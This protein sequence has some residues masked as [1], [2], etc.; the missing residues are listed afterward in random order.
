MYTRNFTI[1]WEEKYKNKANEADCKA[2]PPAGTS[3]AL[4]NI[5]CQPAFS[6][7]LTTA[8]PDFQGR[9]SIRQQ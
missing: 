4:D 3:S 1:I 8:N 2:V 6:W 9:Q 7:S 5:E